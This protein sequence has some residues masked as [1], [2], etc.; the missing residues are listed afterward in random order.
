MILSGG[1]NVFPQEVE[2]L[3]LTHPA[4]AD[5]AVFGVPDP[6]FGQRLAAM[7]VPEGGATGSVGAGSGVGEDELRQFVRERLARHKVPREIAFVEALPRTSTGKLQR[8]KLGALRSER[9]SE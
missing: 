7:V 2:E 6:D 4:V 3:L 8:R 9:I 5:A 1:E